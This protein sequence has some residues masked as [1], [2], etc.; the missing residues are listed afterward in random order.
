M[1]LNVSLIPHLEGFVQQTVR[2]GRFPSASEV[3]R[4][5]LRPM[6]YQEQEQEAWLA[7]LRGEIKKGL[8]SAEAKLFAD[9]F[10]SELRGRLREKDTDA[11]HD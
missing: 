9:G 4:T 3:V 10:W 1:T 2:S 5:A 11:S 6:E 7:W 8:D